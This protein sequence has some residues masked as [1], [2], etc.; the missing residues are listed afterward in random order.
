MKKLILIALTALSINAHAQWNLK[1]SQTQPLTGGQTGAEVRGC[2]TDT[3][4]NIYVASNE[5][6]WQPGALSGKIT[7]YDDA[8]NLKWSISLPA[9]ISLSQSAYDGITGIYMD[10]QG[11]ALTVAYN[12]DST[13]SHLIKINSSGSIAW[14]IVVNGINHMFTGDVNQDGIYVVGRTPEITCGAF[15]CNGIAVAKYN[16]SGQLQWKKT[17]YTSGFKATTSAMTVD[18]AGSLIVCGKKTA[19]SITSGYYDKTFVLKY[20]VNG[21]LLW[22]KEFIENTTIDSK[23][24]LDSPILETNFATET[25]NTTTGIISTK[26]RHLNS[27]GMVLWTKTINNSELRRISDSG[28]APDYIILSASTGMRTYNATGNLIWSNSIAMDDQGM[29]LT[30]SGKLYGISVGNPGTAS[31]VE[32][33]ISNGNILLEKKLSGGGY[34][35]DYIGLKAALDGGLIMFINNTSPPFGTKVTKLSPCS[36]F[37]FSQHPL[38]SSVT[39]VS[40]ASCNNGAI[41]V[42]WT[43]TFNSWPHLELYNS[44]NVLQQQVDI[45][46]SGAANYIFQNLTSGSYTVKL[47]DESCGEQ[48]INVTVKC[49]VPSS[50]FM[51]ITSSPGSIALSW[52]A[53]GCASGFKIQYS[54]NGGV[55]WT[56]I[57]TNTPSK[58]IS[59]LTPGATYKWRVATKCSGTN[60]AVYTG[61]SAIQTFT[62]PS[63]RLGD[64]E[65]TNESKSE[66]QKEIDMIIFPNPVIDA[67]TISFEI[68]AR[69]FHVQVLN[70]IGQMVIEQNHYAKGGLTQK[71]LNVSKLPN[72]IYFLKVSSSEGNASRRFIKQ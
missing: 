58:N 14:D 42:N 31:L 44:T 43:G 70:S 6:V 61:Y 24:L 49:P 66:H 48:D 12:T 68:D 65:T 8:G 38:S 9:A 4:G 25:I 57:T 30:S 21:T 3:S 18:S 28:T 26:L 34:Q 35:G 11:A 55:S 39:N 29:E 27:A 64:G 50:G 32:I 45:S 2:A 13:T 16:S 20:D 54:S 7:K 53:P 41:A 72:G 10:D 62:M 36:E 56:T 22:S 67:L 19:S 47:F 52:N 23:Q 5:Y 63:Q 15:Q 69:D 40:G 51:A 1:W 71:Q 46:T 17:K 37:I 59:G 33:E 60:P